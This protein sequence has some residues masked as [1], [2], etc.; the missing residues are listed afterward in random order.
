MPQRRLHSL[1][2]L[3]GLA[4]LAVVLWHW[5]HFFLFGRMPMEGWKRDWQ[6]LY[7]LFKPAYLYGWAMVDLFFALSGFVFC[8]L[9]AEAIAQR[10][11]TPGRFALLRFSR[12]YP[13]HW[14]TLAAVAAMQWSYW[15]AVDK[16]F[17]YPTNDVFY[18]AL[19]AA[20]VQNWFHGLET[21]NGP[22]WSVSIEVLLYIVFFVLCRLRLM[23]WRVAL[24]MVAI[25]FSI[26][27]FH[28]SGNTGRG[29]MAF[30]VGVI[31]F[32]A[33]DKIRQHRAARALSGLFIGLALLG[34]SVVIAQFYWQ[35]LG[36]LIARGTAFCGD[37]V[38]LLAFVALVFAPTLM[39]LSLHEWVRGADYSRLSF[40]G[41]ISYSTYMLHF[42]MQLALANIAVR[43]GWSPIMFQS[44]FVLIAFY[45]V[46]IGLGLLSYRAFERPMQAI[47][48]KRSASRTVAMGDR[49]T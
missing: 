9:Y 18:F 7:V 27:H 47:L 4:A 30:F 25:G 2:A 13:L 36:D 33:A 35:P 14:L 23:N 46:L 39:A 8:W 44:P 29:V 31:V 19:S 43:A 41:D 11:I 28:L 42:P 3:R 21:F 1:D 22:S 10:R 45:A 15:Q 32:Y 26:R 37:E 17:V 40:L 38:S 12:L 6:P 48:R 5:Q 49:V 24:A 34:W 20:L 16:F